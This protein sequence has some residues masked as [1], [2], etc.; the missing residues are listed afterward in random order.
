LAKSDYEKVLRAIV[1]STAWES[2]KNKLLVIRALTEDVNLFTLLNEFISVYDIA[3]EKRAFRRSA[4]NELDA[5]TREYYM[6]LVAKVEEAKTSLLSYCHV[7]ISSGKPQWQILA[8]KH[9][10]APKN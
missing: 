5:E 10:W 3:I 2:K 7:L 1:Q 4:F 6:R 9:G 8:E